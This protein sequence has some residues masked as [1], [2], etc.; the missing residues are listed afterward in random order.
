MG[1]A[2]AT[3]ICLKRE[4]QSRSFADP[5]PDESIVKT[6]IQ[7][8]SAGNAGLYQ[9]RHLTEEDICALRKKVF[10]HDFL[11]RTSTPVRRLITRLFNIN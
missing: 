8:Y 7:R 10:R 4:A 11:R 5:R 1:P 3:V 9:G 6:L 2:P